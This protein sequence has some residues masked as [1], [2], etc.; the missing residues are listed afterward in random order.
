[1]KFLDNIYIPAWLERWAI[2]ML[3]AV[4]LFF[5]LV[6][7]GKLKAQSLPVPKEI[8]YV[9]MTIDEYNELVGKSKCK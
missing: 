7:C 9:I 1:M 3:I 5:S 6:L 2:V 4:C 8:Q